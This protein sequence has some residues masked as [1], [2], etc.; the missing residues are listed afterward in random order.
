[1]IDAFGAEV[2]MTASAWGRIMGIAANARLHDAAVAIV[3]LGG[4]ITSTA[5]NLLVLPTL[6]L[7][8]GR[9]ERKM[10]ETG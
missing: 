5:L 7:P 1:M 4:L 3:I 2:M 10:D 6:A 9:F 8:F